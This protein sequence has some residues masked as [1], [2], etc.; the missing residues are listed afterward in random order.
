MATIRI[1]ERAGGTHEFQATISFYT[2][3]EYALT[4]NN[5]FA[6]EEDDQLAWYFEGYLR[7]PFTDQVKAREAAGSIARYGESLF[8]QV[9]EE[10]HNV[11]ARYKAAVQAGLSTVQFEIAGSPLF[12]TLHWEALKDPEIR[13]P[14]ALQATMVRKNLNP[15][16]IEAS[17]RPSPTIKLLIVT[18][19]PSGRSDVGYRTISRPLVEA[20]RQA[21]LPVQ[22]DILRPGTYK[23]LEKHL[24]Q[25]SA[26]RQEGYYQVIHFDLHGSVLTYEQLQQV[27]EASRH[28]Y[29]ER[30]GRSDIQPYEGVKAFLAF[31]GAEDTQVDRVEASELADLLVTHRVSIAILNACQ[32]GKQIGESET[33][34]GSRLMQ[35]GVQLVLAM[36]YSVTVSAAER[37]MQTLYQHLFAGEEL[38]AAIRH[39]RTELYNHKA[40]RAYFEQQIDLED[41][42]LPVVY[43]N[44]PVKVQPREFTP[45]EREAWYE[46]KAEEQ[47]YTP[48]EPHYGFVGRDLDILEIERRLLLKRNLLLVRGMG[49]AG[50]TTLLRHL[51][52]WWHTTGFVERV[53]YFGYDEK[54]WTLEQIMMEMAQQLYGP[55]YYTNFQP[56]SLAARQAMLA[57]ELRS[58]HHLLILDNLE[59]ITG[60]E[61]AIQHTLPPDEQARLRSFL[62]DLAKGRTLVLLGS[63]GGE[64]WLAQGTFED[65]VYE[66]PG[67]DPEAASTLA[68]RILEKHN[69]TKYREDAGFQKLLKLLDGFPLAL[70]VILAN[71]AQQA[72]GEVLAA[73][74]A[75]DVKLDTPDSQ[76]K[77]ESILR[78][79]DYSHSN[80]SPEAQQLLLCLAPFTLVI[81]L[82][83]LNYYTEQ[84]RQQPALASLPFERWPEVLREAQNWGLL[85]PDPDIPSFLRLQP[86]FPYFLRSRLQEPEQAEVK[87]A[88]EHAF[89]EYY[90][91][92]GA[93]LYSLLSSQD[94]QERRVGQLLAGL[95]YENLVTALTLALTAETSIA[96]Y[97]DALLHYLV[98]RQNPRRSL[99]LFQAILDRFERYPAEKLA[100]PLGFEFANVL[101]NMANRQHELKQYEAAET[102]YQK[103]LQLVPQLVQ[104]DQEQ[105]KR[106][107]ALA[108]HNLGAVA[109]EQRQFEQAEEYYQQA[110]QIYSEYNDRYSQTM[111]YHNL[112]IIAQEQRQFEQAEQYYQQALRLKIEFNDRYSQAMT[113]HQLG[114][115]A[116]EQRQFEQAEQ[117]YQQALRL[118]IEFNDRYGQASTNHHLGWIAQEQRQFAQAAQCYQQALQLFIEF[119]DRY[120]QA[121]TYHNL[122]IMAQ[123]QRQFEQAEQY[124]QQALQLKVEFNDHYSQA[125]TYHS[126]GMVAQEQHQWEQAAQYYQQALEIY[127]EYNDRYEQA[128]TYGQLGILERERE[129]WAQAREYS[130]RALEIYVDYQDHENIARVLRNLAHLWQSSN[131]ADLPAAITTMLGASRE[132]IEALLRKSLE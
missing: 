49:G 93:N 76:E 56:L 70:E 38:S 113:Y 52:A 80:L 53:F 77:T 82:N 102:S 94:G 99:A 124:Y 90:R 25:T 15:S 30:Y 65:T 103:I 28:L 112:G 109:Q 86:I 125:M 129:Q 41:W 79:I 29:N 83:P 24:R 16:T 31:E 37:L 116:Q 114:I 42:L 95:E 59:S 45:G 21:N 123:Q 5:P 130:L 104:L 11:Y 19:R 89:R 126:L 35:A 111:T 9:F 48:P 22:I 98:A 72:P 3:P 23:A 57:H 92:L 10:N 78:C 14:L 43:Q 71:L 74:Q 115:V 63:R 106:L 132:E 39:A 110:L 34:L 6:Q 54:A 128:G 26:Q 36:G 107:Q 58:V 69:A 121:N 7:F 64:R 61:L 120:S 117:Y 1:Q 47:R 100:G 131:D 8:K 51:G 44:Q 119:N 68:D 62:A 32:S 127:S 27:Q 60:A 50:K 13:L 12:H 108:Y 17:V 55:Q 97:Y 96:G 4:I 2:G 101:G 67:L 118:K 84:L 73:L 18:A 87:Q 66:L 88:V 75:G 46:R 105:A 20:L 122:G 33:S 40:R 81:W 85:S 91:H